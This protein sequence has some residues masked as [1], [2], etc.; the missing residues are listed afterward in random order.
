M[1]N[2]E[3]EAKEFMKKR[4]QTFNIMDD[5]IKSLENVNKNLETILKKI[6]DLNAKDNTHT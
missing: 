6:K 3:K 2:L 5:V 1:H 4:K